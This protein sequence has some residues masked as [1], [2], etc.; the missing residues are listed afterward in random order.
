M[1]KE[2][3]NEAVELLKMLIATPSVS[4]DEAAAAAVLEAYMREKGLNPKRH[5]N[6]VWCASPNFDESKPVILLNA[7][8]DTVKPVAGW[9]HDPFTPTFEGD[10]SCF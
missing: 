2:Q 5:G 4:R 7:H 10:K 8:V 9:V 1:Y 3:T 6:N